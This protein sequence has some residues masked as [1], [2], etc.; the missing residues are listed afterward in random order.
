MACPT[1]QWWQGLNRARELCVCFQGF[2]CS[3]SMF[4]YRNRKCFLVH[5]QE[6]LTRP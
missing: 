2:L 1:C 5:T 6:A 3:L 4:P